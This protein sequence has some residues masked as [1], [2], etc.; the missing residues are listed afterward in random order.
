MILGIAM[1]AWLPRW[2]DRLVPL[3]QAEP[4]RWY[5]LTGMLGVLI[6]WRC[7]RAVIEPTPA[8]VRMAVAHCV[9]SIMMLDAVACYAV[10]GVF[11]AVLILLLLLPAMFLGRWI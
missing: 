7:F 6:V 8:R 11:W 3:L 10:R 2:S 5:L 1:L 4:Q 9:L